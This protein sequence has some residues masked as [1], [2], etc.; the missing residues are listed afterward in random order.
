MILRTLLEAYLKSS[1]STFTALL[2]LSFSD[3]DSILNS[4][5]ALLLLLLILA[6]PP[7]IY[8]FLS[9]NKHRLQD[10]NFKLRF[11]S[12]YLNVNTRKDN[13]LLM[14]TLFVTR[15]L[16]FALN[17]VLLKGY[18][19]C[20]IFMQFL[21]SLMLLLFFVAV[22]PLNSA[23]LNGMEIFN[24]LVLLLASYFLF[25]FTYFVPDA[26]TR[27]KLGWCFIALVLTLIVVNWLAI[28]FKMVMLV[29]EIIRNRRI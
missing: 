13:A 5:I 17:V 27:Y 23:F 9:K 10:D 2:L 1:I 15:Q 22:R 25:C 7:L 29:R 8:V 19:N 12:L 18:T 20:Q 24:E 11:F 21:T 3:R 6:I 28:S 4:S 14:M 16:L 26:H